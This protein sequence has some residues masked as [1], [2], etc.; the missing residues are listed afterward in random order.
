M[1]VRREWQRAAH[2]RKSR[3]EWKFT[4][5]RREQKKKQTSPLTSSFDILHR[6][7]G[8]ASVGKYPTFCR[9]DVD[10]GSA[11]EPVTLANVSDSVSLV[12][13]R[14]R[15]PVPNFSTFCIDFGG[16]CDAE[17]SSR[18]SPRRL[19]LLLAVFPSSALW[20][21]PH[22]PAGPLSRHLAQP[23][24]KTDLDTLCL[25]CKSWRSR[26]RSWSKWPPMKTTPMS[27]QESIQWYSERDVLVTIWI[28]LLSR[29]PTATDAHDFRERERKE[30]RGSLCRPRCYDILF[31]RE[32]EKQGPYFYT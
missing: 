19:L 22:T 14:R 12:A 15:P 8:R 31:K 3:E 11:V 9:I 6:F 20:L 5:T 23:F 17:V 26:T 27:R 18:T 30:E 1:Q 25:F 10:P 21:P 13:L 7:W 4:N 32:C 29:Q 24:P 16:I 2:E 28:E